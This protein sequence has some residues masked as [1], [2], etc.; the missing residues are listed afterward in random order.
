MDGTTNW[1]RSWMSGKSRPNCCLSRPKK[2]NWTTKCLPHL[3][4]PE[5]PEDVAA[6]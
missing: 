1:T 3:R 6:Q 2:T 4:E 5:L